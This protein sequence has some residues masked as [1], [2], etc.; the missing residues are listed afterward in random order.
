[1]LKKKGLYA[2]M[3]MKQQ[4]VDEARRKLAEAAAAEI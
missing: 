1:L 2:T 4:Q 3:W